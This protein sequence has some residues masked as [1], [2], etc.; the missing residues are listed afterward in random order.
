[1]ETIIFLL[2]YVVIPTFLV[3][4][5]LMLP[6]TSN[7]QWTFVNH[8]MTSL[9]YPHSHWNFTSNVHNQLTEPL[10]SLWPLT[11]AWVLFGEK[12]T[13]KG[14]FLTIGPGLSS[15]VRCWA[16]VWAE[17]GR[18]F[19]TKPLEA[20]L[21][22]PCPALLSLVDS[23]AGSEFYDIP[24]VPHPLPAPFLGPGIRACLVCT[25]CMHM[26]PVHRLVA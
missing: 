3:Y 6:F 1:M 25:V 11:N 26:C 12:W 18:Y 2:E 7:L 4:L 23:N 20:T 24:G 17:T 9:T 19:S 10:A 8:S 22:Q 5:I 15:Q 21:V 13:I 14:Q 16:D